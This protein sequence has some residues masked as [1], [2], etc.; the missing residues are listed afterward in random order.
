MEGQLGSGWSGRSA[1]DQ[2]AIASGLAK[3]QPHMAVASSGISALRSRR[4]LLSRFIRIEGSQALHDTASAACP[5]PRWPQ[6]ELT[7]IIIGIQ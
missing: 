3:G 7:Q 4:D 5:G 6:D 1:R 2:I